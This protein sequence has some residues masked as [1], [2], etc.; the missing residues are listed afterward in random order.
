MTALLPRLGAALCA[1]VLVSGCASSSS[2]PEPTSS[3]AAAAAPARAAA[4]GAAARGAGQ[5]GAGQRGAGVEEQ[6]ASLRTAVGLTDEQAAQ[7]RTILEAQ[8]AN[9]PTRG[10]GGDREA[11]RAQ[12]QERRART[13]AEIEAVLTPEQVERFRTWSAA[14]RPQGGRRGGPPNN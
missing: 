8:Q 6:L 1:L 14:Q 11:M 7:V 12:M 5:R 9:R 4:G 10:A 2:T 3:S 13:Q